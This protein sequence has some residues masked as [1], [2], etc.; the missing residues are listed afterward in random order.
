MAYTFLSGLNKKA[1]YCRFTL[2]VKHLDDLLEYSHVFLLRKHWR[3]T[4]AMRNKF[5]NIIT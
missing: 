2:S 3:Y 5:L 1:G 4:D